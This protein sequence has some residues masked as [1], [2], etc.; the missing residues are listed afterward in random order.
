MVEL[1]IILVWAWVSWWHSKL[2]GKS[3]TYAT[4][5]ENVIVCSGGDVSGG[6]GD[7]GGNGGGGGGGGDSSSSSSI[8]SDLVN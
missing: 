3:K 7:G 8:A 5:S 4:G 6:G 2:T 1:Y